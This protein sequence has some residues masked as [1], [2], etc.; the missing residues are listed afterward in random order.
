MV[1]KQYVSK[2]LY[3]FSQEYRQVQFLS[4]DIKGRFG[5]PKIFVEN[6]K[7]MPYD[8]TLKFIFFHRKLVPYS[9]PFYNTKGIK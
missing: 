4:N 2:Q 9:N 6:K 1:T 5:L 7:L 8:C 3:L